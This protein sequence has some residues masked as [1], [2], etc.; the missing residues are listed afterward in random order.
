VTESR[1]EQADK[2]ACEI[3]SFARN[4]L[5]FSMRF[6][7]IALYKP[8]LEPGG[9]F[10]FATDAER[11]YFDSR[12]IFDVYRAEPSAVNRDFLHIVLHCVFHHLFVGAKVNPKL[13]D[14]ACDV[15]VENAITELKIGA[16]SCLREKRQEKAIAELSS[17]GVKP[18]TAEKI[19]RH[20]L[21]F[22]ADDE[23]IERIRRE[24]YADDH[25]PW[26]AFPG[27]V[28]DEQNEQEQ[29]AKGGSGDGNGKSGEKSE[30]NPNSENQTPNAPDNEARATKEE[31]EENWKAIAEK[32][33]TELE[34]ASRQWSDVA[35][36][37]TQNLR[38]VTREKYD[39][40]EFLRR[41]AVLGEELRIN[42]DE[43]D[44]VFYT[45]GLRLY[46]NLPLVEPLEYKE[47]KRVREFVIAID[48]SASVSGELVQA[49]AQKTFNILKQSE[50]YFSRIN[51]R[52]IQCDTV[53]QDDAKIT[54]QEEFD[55][56]LRAMEL[57]GLG[58]TDFRPVFRYVDELI[59]KGE[60]TNLRGLI[61]FTDGYGTF[62]EIR[63]RYES[64]FVFIDT[65]GDSV[66]PNVPVWA[67]KLILKPEEI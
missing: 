28:S 67:I 11:I 40:A 29:K 45:Y 8:E 7:A 47:V 24:F 21:D 3:L 19:Y 32:V 56:Y 55:R 17:A 53:I 43:F 39:Y 52:I 34:T 50:T 9:K 25:S 4:S 35:G 51:L 5:M 62:P 2:L 30:P 14:L 37:L 6:M 23:Q 42:D 64:A 49:F 41:F 60:F 1:S 59:A 44:Y 36:A 38:E 65:G 20:Y 26:Y 63:P 22:A 58:G 46:D 61:Y 16:L 33:Q 13:W 15:A 54:N 12:H 18:L 27:S 57:K 31:L 66:N 48:T 10:A